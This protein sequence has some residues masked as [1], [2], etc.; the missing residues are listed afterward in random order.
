MHS[1][2]TRVVFEWSPILVGAE[3]GKY[4]SLKTQ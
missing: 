3:A 2:V 1:L 4:S